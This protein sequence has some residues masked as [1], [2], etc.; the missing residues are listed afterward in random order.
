MILEGRLVVK[1]VSTFWPISLMCEEKLA[2]R[3]ENGHK[4]HLVCIPSSSS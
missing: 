4:D 1:T 3:E 2:L